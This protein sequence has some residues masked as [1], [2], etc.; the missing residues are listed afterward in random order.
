VIERKKGDGIVIAICAIIVIAWLA[1][2]AMLVIGMLVPKADAHFYAGCKHRRCKE[3]VIRP[4]KRTFLAPVGACETRGWGGGTF[5]LRTGL[6]TTSPN[7]QYRGRY[8]F[9]LPDWWRAGGK[10]DPV[11]AG[12]REQAY[13]AVIW[14]HWNG[15]SSWPNC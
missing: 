8:Q 11:D 12:W 7:G 13:R 5:D 15:R 3:H 14:L 1:F 2:L 6:R 10:G 9:G 4:Y